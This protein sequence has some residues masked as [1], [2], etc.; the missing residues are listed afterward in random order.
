M[1]K[2]DIRV[3]AECDAKA[4]RFSPRYT[5]QFPHA[6]PQEHCKNIIPGKGLENISVDEL[7]DETTPRA[8]ANVPDGVKAEL[9]QSKLHRIRN[10]LQST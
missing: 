2:A 1:E 9:L 7:V 3:M 6:S 10:L 5:T 4:C 8:R